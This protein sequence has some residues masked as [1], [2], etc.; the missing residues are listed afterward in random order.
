MNIG[1]NPTYKAV[2]RALN[3]MAK[4]IGSPNA[5]NPNSVTNRTRIVRST[6]KVPFLPNMEIN[7]RMHINVNP[8]GIAR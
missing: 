8:V 3:N 7:N 5:M 1:V 2:D 6:Y 4:A